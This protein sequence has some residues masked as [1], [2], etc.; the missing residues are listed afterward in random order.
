MLAV[1]RKMMFVLPVLIGENHE[2]RGEP[3]LAMF[4]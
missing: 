2:I 3:R 4:K 1:L